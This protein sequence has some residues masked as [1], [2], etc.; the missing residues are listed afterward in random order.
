MNSRI[1]D[2]LKKSYIFNGFN[3]DELRSLLPSDLTVKEF[4]RG[5]PI[6]PCEESKALCII[7]E[8]KAESFNG[9]TSINIF[10]AGDIFGAASLFCDDEYTTYIT[11]KT[12]GKAVYFSEAEMK[13]M[14]LS[15]PELT[16]KFIGFLSQKIYQL[17]RK[18]SLFTSDSAA[19]N[20]AKFLLDCSHGKK[21][22][23]L[24]VSMAKLSCKLSM[25]R[26]S[27]YRSFGTIEE[28]GAITRDKVHIVIK[29]KNK[30]IELAKG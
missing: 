16:L 10:G 12:K 5:E 9:T 22:F 13:D 15:S 18:I 7:I 24:P 6:F 1:V 11:A 21:E 23:D 27:L 26:A 8:G 25:G 19:S 20:I 2:A 17:N 4:A 29:D 3:T 30:L 28:S 14:L